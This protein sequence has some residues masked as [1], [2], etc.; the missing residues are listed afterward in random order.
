MWRCY[1]VQVHSADSLPHNEIGWADIFS[2]SP[3]S[4]ADWGDERT[5]KGEYDRVVE[6]YGEL[7]RRPNSV[8]VD[9]EFFVVCVDIDQLQSTDAKEKLKS[10][11]RLSINKRVAIHV[12]LMWLVI[13]IR[14]SERNFPCD[15]KIMRVRSFLVYRC[16]L[17]LPDVWF[18]IFSINNNCR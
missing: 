18:L 13:L 16:F 4:L 3:S 12:N 11:L 6:E 14:Q 8:W 5:T 2:L 7:C 10:L 9:A 17:I 1:I 15:L